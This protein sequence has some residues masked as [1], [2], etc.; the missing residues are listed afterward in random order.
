MAASVEVK[1][2]DVSNSELIEGR[3]VTLECA[4]NTNSQA[5]TVWYK[6]GE[7]IN[8]ATTRNLK[9]FEKLRY[10]LVQMYN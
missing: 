10:W 1:L 7:V 2:L 6:N 8:N 4:N 9:N 5:W 3:T